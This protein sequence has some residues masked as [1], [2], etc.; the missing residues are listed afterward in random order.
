MRKGIGLTASVI[1]DGDGA[2][3]SVKSATG[4]SQAFAIR[5]TDTT[6]PA[7]DAP[8]L[9]SLSVNDGDGGMLVGSEAKDAVVYLDGARFTR[10]SNTINNLITGVRLDLQSTSASAVTLG[11]S[12]PTA[13]LSQAASDFV[14]TYNQLQAVIKEQNDPATGVLKADTAVATMARSLAA[15]T[16]TQL[17]STTAAGVPR[18]LADIGIGTNRDGTLKLD[19]AR[20]TSVLATYPAAVE[21]IFAR[22]SGATNGGLSAALSAIVTRATDRTYGIDASTT[23]YT[24]QQTAITAEQTKA[25]DAAATMK[26]RLTQQFAAMD[27]KVAAYKS[28]QTFLDNQIKAWNRSDD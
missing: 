17:A 25:T 1:G 27:A 2:R 23:R 15:L 5:A 13:A 6:T 20:M 7:A 22:G 24:G 19:T 21:A 3:L 12:S 11:T 14:E 16:T 9:T 26:T 18:T 10:A 8:S 4:A 28:T